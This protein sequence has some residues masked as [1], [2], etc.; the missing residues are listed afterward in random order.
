MQEQETGD[1]S[2]VRKSGGVEGAVEKKIWREPVIGSWEELRE[3]VPRVKVDGRYGMAGSREILAQYWLM[4]SLMSR[5]PTRKE[6]E[7]EMPRWKAFFGSFR[8]LERAAGVVWEKTAKGWRKRVRKAE[9]AR[10]MPLMG[11]VMATEPVNEQGV[12][13][14]FGEMAKELGFVIERIGTR[15]PDCVAMRNVGG[16]WEMVRIEFEFVSSRFD[17]DP[18]G[19]DLVVCWKDD[20]KGCPVEVLALEEK[21]R[22]RRENHRAGQS[23]AG[24]A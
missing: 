17:H 22:E 12:V 19:C 20:W 3:R 18:A 24:E 11:R 21:A 7:E 10:G 4:F 5:R 16:V 6:F 23:V 8:D 2:G 1:V 9:P 15:F 14:L 13:A